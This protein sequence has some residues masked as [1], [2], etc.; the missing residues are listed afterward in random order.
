MGLSRDG[1]EVISET[2]VDAARGLLAKLLT[3]DHELVTLI[4]GE[5]AAAGETRQITEWLAEHHPSVVAEV[6]QGGQPLYP[7]V[8][9]IE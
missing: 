9:S 2:M 8:I 5:G 7:Y 1:V 3:D 6:H 4:E